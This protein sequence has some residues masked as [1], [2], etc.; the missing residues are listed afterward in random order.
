M[1]DGSEVNRDYNI[2]QLNND[3]VNFFKMFYNKHEKFRGRD[4]YLV[5]QDFT[6]GNYLPAYT[7]AFQ[8]VRDG[9]KNFHDEAFEKKYLAESEKEWDAW[10]KISGLFMISPEMDESI[11]KYETRFYAEKVGLI[12]TVEGPIMALFSDW[13]RSA[14]ESKDYFYEVIACGISESF[15]TGNPIWPIFDLRNFKKSCEN[16]FTCFKND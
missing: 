14:I 8:G 5:A 11:Q 13:C 16:W 7:A 1:E 15:A 12:T 3:F 4:M 2:D 6:A 9:N 10:F